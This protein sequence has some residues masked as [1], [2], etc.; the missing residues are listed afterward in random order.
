M[1][2]RSPVR[3]RRRAKTRWS[4]TVTLILTS[5]V[6]LSGAGIILAA[7]AATVAASAVTCGATRS[8]TPLAPGAAGRCVFRFAES[9]KQAQHQRFTVTLDVDTTA[10]SG[11]GSGDTAS[12]APLDGRATGLHVVVS[13]SAH[14]TFGVG[15]PS[16]SGTYPNATPCS[17]TDHDQAV[18]GAID[19][20][21]WSDTLTIAWTL[22]RSA[23][24]PYQGGSATITVTA[25]F[26][27]TSGASSSPSPSPTS[28]VLA[29]ETPSTGVG[30]IPVLG[31]V[32]IA[33][34]IGLVLCGIRRIRAPS[35]PPRPVP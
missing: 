22:P 29:A 20:S 28:G 27:G 18:R 9:A 19:V 4:R 6:L 15:A 12:E 13:N 11:R 2:I 34:G 30:A 23:G 14:D 33:A 1:T 17:S 31:L 3:R 8:T 7:T 26:N 16:C 5:G 21:H 35:L 10:M 24:N 25:R 32:L